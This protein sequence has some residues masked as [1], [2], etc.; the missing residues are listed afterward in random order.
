MTIDEMA[1]SPPT[2]EAVNKSQPAARIIRDHLGA[3]LKCETKVAL[4]ATIPD[5]NVIRCLTNSSAASAASVLWLIGQV[6]RPVVLR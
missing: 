3:L 4:I 6:H 2:T 5:D 1:F